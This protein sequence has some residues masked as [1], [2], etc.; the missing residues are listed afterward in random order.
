MDLREEG[1]RLRVRV[2]G[3]E[4]Q[5]VADARVGLHV[6]YPNTGDHAF[7]DTYDRQ[8][9]SYLVTD[10]GGLTPVLHLSALGHCF[11]VGAGG[12]R[13][14]DAVSAIYSRPAAVPF[15]SCMAAIA[16]GD[17]RSIE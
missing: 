17:S 4:G 8:H 15:C 16:P 7:L 12:F 9:I 2:V 3:P 1:H 13:K 10:A 11:S 6:Q 5:P 14:V